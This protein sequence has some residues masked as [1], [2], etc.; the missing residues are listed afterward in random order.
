MRLEEQ[1][2]TIEQ[3]VGQLAAIAGDAGLEDQVVVAAGHLEWVEL[4]RPEAVHDRHDALRFGRKSRGGASRWR[5]ARKRR[6][7]ARLIWWAMVRL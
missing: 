3:L 2:P 7:T 4:Q 5:I 1:P 6:A